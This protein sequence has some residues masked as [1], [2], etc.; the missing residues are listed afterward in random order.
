MQSH[1]STVRVEEEKLKS[2]YLHAD[3]Y[4]CCIPDD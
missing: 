4:T 3:G 1:H 2:A